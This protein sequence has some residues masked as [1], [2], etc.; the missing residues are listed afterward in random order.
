VKTTF[1]YLIAPLT[2]KSSFLPISPV[3]IPLHNVKVLLTAT[4]YYERKNSQHRDN[5]AGII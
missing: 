4:K 1:C 3:N 5:T 2:K